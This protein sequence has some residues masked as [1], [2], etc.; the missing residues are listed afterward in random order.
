MPALESL[1]GI[2][3]GAHLNWLFPAEIG[4][5]QNFVE[6]MAGVERGRRG[7]KSARASF[8]PVSQP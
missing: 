6:G 5:F 1:T 4:E 8:T 2:I 7:S 3:P